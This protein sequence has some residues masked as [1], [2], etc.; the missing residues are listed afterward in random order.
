MRVIAYSLYG[1]KR[2]YTE[3]MVRNIELAP[4]VYPGWSVWIYC[5]ETVPGAYL[6][7]YGRYGHVEVKD[8]TGSPYP[9]MMWRFLPKVEVFICR[10]ADS[11]LTVRERECVDEWLASDKK[12]HVMRDHPAH[13][14]PVLGGMWGLKRGPLDMESTLMRFLERFKERDN[15][16]YGIDQQFLRAVYRFFRSQDSVL[17]H[18]SLGWFPGSVPFP[19]PLGPELHF[20]GE[21]FDEKDERRQDHYRDWVAAVG[22]GKER[23]RKIGDHGRTGPIAPERPP[24]P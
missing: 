24:L 16:D 6:E 1:D 5:N 2:M 20:V 23:L 11:R 3:G 7:R 15:W 21:V 17:A 18:D 14:L 8:M 4:L 12:M 19:S 22:A 13:H 10:D 9:G